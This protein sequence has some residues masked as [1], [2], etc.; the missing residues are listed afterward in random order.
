MRRAARNLAISS[1]K[2]LWQLKKKEMRGANSSTSRPRCMRPADVLQAV[3]QGEGQL[4]GGGGARLP[5]VVAADA[6]GVPER[7]L[8]G[9]EL[10]RVRH[11]PHGGL[12][13]EDELLLGDVLLQDVVLDGAAQL[14]RGMPRFSAAA[15]YI[16]QMTAPGR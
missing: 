9:G 5:D 3:G 10:D 13:R 2:S 11:Q 1:K 12:R 6:D 14:E 7:H 15:M 4:L 8:F 16:A